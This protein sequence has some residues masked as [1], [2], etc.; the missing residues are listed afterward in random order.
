M[1]EIYT[2]EPPTKGKVVLH[3]S[4]GDLDVEL[5]SKECPKACRNFVQLCLEGYY[6]NTVFH[7]II[8][9]FCVQGGDPTGTGEGGESIY[10]CP[11]PDEIHSRLKFRYRGLLGVA[12]AGR[13]SNTNGSQFFITLG[14]HSAVTNQGTLT[15]LVLITSLVLTGRCDWLTGQHTLFGKLTGS[16]AYNLVKLSEAET[17]SNDRPRDPPFIKSTEVLWNPFEDIV[18]R[19]APAQDAGGSD[20]SKPKRQKKEALKFKKATFLS[21][22]EDKEAIDISVARKSAHDVLDDPSLLSQVQAN[23]DDDGGKRL[24]PHD[25]D[26][27]AAAADIKRWILGSARSSDN[28][29]RKGIPSGRSLPTS[30]GKGMNGEAVVDQRKDSEPAPDTE[31]KRNMTEEDARL[32][33]EIQSLTV[34][35]AGEGS[36][37]AG[38]RAVK[39]VEKGDVLSEWERK[40]EAYLKRK[41]TSTNRKHQADV[42]QKLTSFRDR[43]KHMRGMDE[44]DAVDGSDT[45]E[46]VGARPLQEGSALPNLDEEIP[47]TDGTWAKRGLRFPV[48]SSRAYAWD[49]A[50]DAVRSSD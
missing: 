41:R 29:K 9:D 3:T 46:L 42:M 2:S 12:N 36:K 25:D 13:G 28:D 43:L 32:R 22:D 14:A 33:R 17:D 30:L 6:D 27:A 16:T 10:G 1:S 47:E 38:T 44:R 49:A 37:A 23:D 24:R 34:E 5:W 35:K 45:G 8:K 26:S 50:K 40:R 11:F 19:R 4:H 48:D 31:K 39:D 20:E 15:S 7:R 21:F 18:L